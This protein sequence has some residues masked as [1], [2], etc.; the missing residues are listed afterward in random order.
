MKTKF[1]NAKI[2]N[3]GYY[4]IK[5]RKEGNHNKYLHRLIFEDF[6][7]YIPDGYFVHHIDGN[8]LNNCILNLQLMRQTVHN[9][10]HNTG[11]LH[12]IEHKIKIASTMEHKTNYFRVHKK[13]RNDCKQGFTWEYQYYKDGKRKGITSVDIDKLRDKVLALDLIWYEFDT[14]TLVGGCL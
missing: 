11:K 10:L 5:T 6:Y 7:G 12:S 14:D 4:Q 9:K 2:N 3:L 13:K 8:P 1:G